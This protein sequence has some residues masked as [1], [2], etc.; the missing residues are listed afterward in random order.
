MSAQTPKI[1]QSDPWLTPY[2][3]I[4]RKRSESAL[5]KE[6]KLISG[7]GSL[8]DFATG[9][10]YFGLH[11]NA[12]GWVFREW[13]PNAIKIYL[14]GDF[15][16]WKEN[17]EYRLV[18]KSFGQWE[19]ILPADALKHKQIYKLLIY[20]DGGKGYRIPSY[21]NRVIQHEETKIFDAQIWQPDTNYSW[22]NKSPVIPDFHPFIYEAHV[23]MATEDENLGTFNEFTD[24]ILPRIVKAG[25]NTVQLMAIQEHPYYGSFGY[26]VSNF[27]AVS[28]RFGSPEDLKNLVDKAHG[29]GL[30]V[31]MDLIHSHSVKNELEGLGLLTDNPIF[32]FIQVRAESIS[33]GI[34]S[35]LI[36]AKMKCYI[37]YCQIVNTGWMNIILTDSGLMA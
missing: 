16:D 7:S 6:K 36:T 3:E 5:N 31:I 11:R 10:L 30:K 27:F 2:A 18:Q 1:I 25:Y 22:K 37:F 24:N 26:H 29:M 13:A 23:G 8:S 21:V 34:H 12:D 28:S 4:I 20:W 32:I 14:I 9:Y 33:H 19:I 17:E 35:V 15:S